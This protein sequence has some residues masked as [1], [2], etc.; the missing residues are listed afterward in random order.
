MNGFSEQQPGEQDGEDGDKVN[1][2]SGTACPGGL[3]ALIIERK[4]HG[5]AEDS[6]IGNICPYLPGKSRQ[7]GE[8]AVPA[9]Q[10]KEHGGTDD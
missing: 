9:R 8:E 1:E 5:G 7:A 3:D 4:T 10:G 2:Y 6:K